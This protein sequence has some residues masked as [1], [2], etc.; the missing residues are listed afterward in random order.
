MGVF[1]HII[2]EVE[3]SCKFARFMLMLNK[4]SCASNI[5]HV[6]QDNTYMHFYKNMHLGVI[7][8]ELITT[9]QDLW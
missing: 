7:G 2:R 9:S 4:S 8:L 6:L 3:Q 1:K 5:N